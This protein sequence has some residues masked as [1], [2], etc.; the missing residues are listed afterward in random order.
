MSQSPH[1]VRE[2]AEAPALVHQPYNS[3]P[4]PIGNHGIDLI[5]P[6][7]QL[8]PGGLSRLTNGIA[9][10]Q[11]GVETRPGLT[12]GTAHNVNS[13]IHS[14][15]RVN[16]PT[17]IPALNYWVTGMGTILRWHASG[18]TPAT[19]DTG[20][21]GD[22]LSLV[23]WT[24]EFTHKSAVYVGDRT[25]MRKVATVTG[26]DKLYRGVD[27]AQDGDLPVRRRGRD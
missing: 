9:T 7:D 18:G 24:N 11:S 22:P 3:F 16:A 19:I 6:V 27:A 25:R 10:P 2:A 4:L 8:P 5:T 20:Y 14:L 17:T 15:L 12:V 21:S 23:S 26:E 13:P 1:P